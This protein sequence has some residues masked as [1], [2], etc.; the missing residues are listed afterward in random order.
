[1][2]RLMKYPSK[3]VHGQF[4]IEPAE[5]AHKLN[6]K[7]WSNSRTRHFP[8]TQELFEFLQSLGTAQR[9]Q[10]KSK[11]VTAKGIGSASFFFLDKKKRRKAFLLDFLWWKEGWG[12]LLAAESELSATDKGSLAHDFEKLLCWKSP[13]KLMIAR[14]ASKVSAEKISNDLGEYARKWV[15]QCAKGECY[16]LFV[17]GTNGNENSAY[18]YVAPKD[19]A[20][21]FRFERISLA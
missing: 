17:F 19:G 10:L 5:L 18:A 3:N 2:M 14:E 6:D 21:D 4:P 7:R 16:V 9:K 1:M 13:L 12:T 20:R 15:P 8:E 11:V